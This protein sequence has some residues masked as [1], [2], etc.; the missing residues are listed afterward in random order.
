MTF[1][2]RDP[3]LHFRW[4]RTRRPS[5]VGIVIHHLD[6]HWDV[7]RTHEFH[8]SL[9]WNGIGYNF[10][11]A[12]DGTISSGCGMGFVGAHTNP[13]AGTNNTTIGVGC[14]GRFH[15]V[16]RTMPDVQYNALVWLIRHLRDIY[17]DIW[18][19]G[20][21]DLA[22]TACPGQFFPLDE[23]RTLRFR[24]REEVQE[25]MAREQRFQSVEEMPNWAQPY[26]EELTSTLAK[27]GRP[28]IRGDQD[29][30][31]DLSLDMIRMAIIF[32]RRLEVQGRE[33]KSFR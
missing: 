26:M 33:L 19:R 16:D 1:Q 20:H 21:R 9:G 11:I 18:I 10:H 27:D 23:V 15:S 31:L 17:G 14:E 3:G 24:N 13:P 32:E 30:N 2:I 8:Q 29:G 5:T 25:P 22:A 4:A 6:A 7:H 28:I 12:M